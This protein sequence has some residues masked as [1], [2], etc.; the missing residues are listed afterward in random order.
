[1]GIVVSA[2]GVGYLVGSLLAGR[3]GERRLGAVMLGAN[4]ASGIGLIAFVAADLP[5]LM[6]VGALFLGVTGALV[7]ISYMTLRATIPPDALLG[8]VGSTARTISIG[9]SPLGLLTGG[10]LLD[11]VGGRVTILAI[12]VAVLATSLLLL[13]VRPLRE[14]RP[15]RRALPA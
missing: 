11:A 2:Y 13:P 14:A 7:L 4:A 8:R 10:V 15:G 5:L 6:L 3:L 1:V 9:L 12:G